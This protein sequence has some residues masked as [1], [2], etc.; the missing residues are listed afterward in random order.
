MDKTKKTN[1]LAVAS[2]S[3]QA[4]ERLRKQKDPTRN[5]KYLFELLSVLILADNNVTEAYTRNLTLGVL[6]HDPHSIIA[7]VK[8]D[9]IDRVVAE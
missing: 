4:F 6:S 9:L 7:N 5:S 1:P 8:R 3:F 2:T